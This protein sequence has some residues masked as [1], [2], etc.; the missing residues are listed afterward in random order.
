MGLLAR[1][2]CCVQPPAT[3][4][5]LE[6]LGLLMRDEELQILKVSLAVVAPRARQELLHV[7][8]LS[9]LLPHCYVSRVD[10]RVKGDGLDAGAG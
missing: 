5:A 7:G 3:A 9:L 6:V 8:L 1:T 2:S 4:V 10:G